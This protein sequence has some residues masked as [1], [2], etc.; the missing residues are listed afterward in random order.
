[1]AKSIFIR[2]N[3]WSYKTRDNQFMISHEGSDRCWW[4]AKI[5]AESSARFGWDIPIE[6]SKTYH[7]SLRN[8]MDWVE[9]YEMPIAKLI[10]A[11]VGA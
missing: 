11:K 5:D 1:M 9:K 4:S 6:N 10:P 2:I 8:S 3:G 7:T